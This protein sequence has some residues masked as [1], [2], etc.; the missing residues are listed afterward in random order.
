MRGFKNASFLSAGTLLSQVI[1]FVGFLFIVRLFGPERYG[2]YA[3]VLAFVMFFHLFAFNGLAKIIV[4][5]GS[6]DLDFFPR[7]LEKTFGLRMAFVL[8]ALVLCIG[9]SFFTKYP[10]GT[11]VLIIIFSTEIIYFGL[12]S[13]LG[14]IYQTL[15]KMQYMAYFSL[16]MRFLVAALSI[17]FLYL[18]AGVAVILAVN[19]L[20]KFLVLSLNYFWSRT[21]IRFRFQP[22]VIL[23]SAILKATVVF[24]LMGFVNT[25]A[26]K[27]DVLMVTFLSGA[28]DV[29]LYSAAH[30]LGREGL[31]FRNIMAVAFFPVA[32]KFFKANKL[33]IKTLF[34]YAF[35]L[36]ILVLAG[37]L[38]VSF[39]SIDLVTLFFKKE[40]VISG[41][42][43]R[44]LIFYLPF[45]FFSLPL[46]T[47]LQATH[48][49]NILLAVYCLTAVTNI[50]LN[51]VLYYRFGLMGIAYSTLAV[52]FL[53][54]LLISILTVWKMKK[55]GHLV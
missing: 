42:I 20:S 23:D 44:V 2:V 27:I 54:S 8:L 41:K 38:V 13:F 30:E 33:K 25:L 18:G 14:S 7:V 55:Q 11:K 28:R 39:F 29:G 46:T 10:Q 45:T 47:S 1:G 31:I 21:L 49:E 35:G 4:R 3:T 24:S 51:L 43:L 48:N 5:E 6:K 12:D 17:V 15:E 19:L 16:L 22:R 9:V 26:V 50:P 34:L 36:F 37:S 52:F 53:E 40:Y 32:V